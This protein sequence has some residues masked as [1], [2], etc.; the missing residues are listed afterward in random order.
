MRSR[1]R[2]P[3]MRSRHKWV[4]HFRVDLKIGGEDMDWISLTQD[5]VSL[6][7]YV[8]MIVNLWVPLKQEAAEQLSNF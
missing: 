6:T 4:D 1:H 2:R 5:R 3:F 7:A 8:N